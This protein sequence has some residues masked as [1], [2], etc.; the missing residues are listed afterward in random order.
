MGLPRVTRTSITPGLAGMMDLV[1]MV[2]ESEKEPQDMVKRAAT[3]MQE[4]QARVSVVLNK[5]R[6]FVPARLHREL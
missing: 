5:L 4:S 1:L 2:V 3:L 6:T